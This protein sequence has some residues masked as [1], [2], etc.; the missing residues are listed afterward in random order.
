MIPFPTPCH[1]Q[2]TADRELDKLLKAGVLEPVEHA[3]DWCSRGF[4]V[5]KNTHCEEV[6]THLVSDLRRVNKVL[7]RIGPPLDGSSHILKRLNPED[8]LYAVCDLSMGYHQLELHPDSRDL[9]SI[10]L[11]RGKYRYACMPQGEKMEAILK[12]CLKRNMKL[13]P[14][15]FQ[16]A[17]QVAFGGVTIDSLIQKVTVKL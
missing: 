2:N 12:L 16:C 1:L 10:V 7:K 14:S 3:T 11:P 6:K 15:R 9:F 17:H 5:Q 4:F 13:S 8:K